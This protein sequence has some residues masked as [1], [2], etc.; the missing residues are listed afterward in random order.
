M[1]GSSTVSK[2]T[3][4][5]DAEIVLD[6]HELIFPAHVQN[7]LKAGWN[8]YFPLSDLKPENCAAS[9]K[10]KIN[11]EKKQIIF[12]DGRLVTQHLDTDTSADNN[13]SSTDYITAGRRLAKAIQ[14]HF[15]PRN[16]AV[17]LAGQVRNHFDQLTERTDFTLHFPRDRAYTTRIFKMWVDSSNGYRL[18]M[19]QDAIY[20]DIVEKDRDRDAHSGRDRQQRQ[21][22]DE[23]NGR[24][25]T[26]IRGEGGKRE[27]TAG[28]QDVFSAVAGTYT[29]HSAAQRRPAAGTSTDARSAEQGPRRTPPLRTLPNDATYTEL[30]PIV[31]PLKA[32]R[33]KF[34]I[35]KMGLTGEYADIPKGIRE[36]F[37]H[38][39]DSS[40]EVKTTFIPVT[41]CQPSSSL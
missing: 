23:R 27:A 6:P 5:I 16:I 12:E 11:R 29:T 8:K 37:A 41:S 3:I 15:E 33:S 22:C 40:L 35:A 19:F 14:K 24:G 21:F 10:E 32:D 9:N 13:L 30:F 1:S 36:G 39:I 4:N 31:T 38:G 17:Q 25:A 34:W 2:R 20:A 7:S 26:T 28:R 18:D